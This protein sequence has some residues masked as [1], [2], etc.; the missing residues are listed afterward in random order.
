MKRLRRCFQGKD[1]AHRRPPNEA[2]A[3]PAIV[4]MQP[5]ACARGTARLAMP[6]PGAAGDGDPELQEASAAA[7]AAGSGQTGPYATTGVTPVTSKALFRQSFA[8]LH[9]TAALGD[10]SC[11]ALFAGQPKGPPEEV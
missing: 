8:V 6:L 11:A 7:C 9:A 1:S 10:R 2:A 5:P 4:R 3:I